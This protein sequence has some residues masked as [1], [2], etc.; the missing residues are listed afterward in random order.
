[1]TLQKT[2]YTIIQEKLEHRILHGLSCEWDNAFWLLDTSYR[3]H[4]HKPLFTLRDMTRQWGCWSGDRNEISLSRHLVV[5]HSWCAVVEVLLHEMAHQFAE[6]VLCVRDDPPHGPKFQQACELLKA[7]PRASGRIMPLDE[8]ISSLS[9][10][11]EDKILIRVK[12]LMSLAQSRNQHEAEAA[13]TKAY[14]LIKKYNL[15][16][17]SQNE[18]RRFMSLFIG[19][20]A[21][22]HFR[23]A[24]ALAGLLQQYYFVCGIWVPAYVIEKG[25]MG[26]VLEISGTA[27]NVQTALYVHDFISHFIDAQWNFYNRKKGLNRY[28]RTDFAVGIVEGFRSKLQK[29]ADQTQ[30]PGTDHGLMHISDPM[31]QAYMKY[32]YPRTVNVKGRPVKNDK[33]VMAD[34]IKKGKEL[35]IHKGISEQGKK[36]RLLN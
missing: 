20:P 24:Y 29:H 27:Q 31:L 13:M 16:L 34:G 32:R 8:R 14:E 6:Q 12:K 22:R 9:Q 30:K 5:N 23:E 28:R 18:D 19:R 11:A 10:N 4:F 26:R 17:I 35:V 2:K 1:M 21:L 7:N 25:G 36:I 3:K 15:D 33:R